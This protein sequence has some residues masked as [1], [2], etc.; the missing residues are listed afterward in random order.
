MRE[1]STKGTVF[2]RIFQRR[3]LSKAMNV[4]LECLN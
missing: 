3:F 4:L 1:V 2:S